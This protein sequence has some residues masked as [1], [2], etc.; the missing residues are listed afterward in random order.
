MTIFLAW[1]FSCEL[2][3]QILNQCWDSGHYSRTLDWN[4]ADSDVTAKPSKGEGQSGW[5]FSAFISHT[6]LE[7]ESKSYLKNDCLF[8]S[9]KSF[10]C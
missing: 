7:K 2:T 8:S 5:G 9:S 10:I 1:P 4:H 3:I 6:E